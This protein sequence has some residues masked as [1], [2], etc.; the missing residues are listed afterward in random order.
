MFGN[1]PNQRTDEPHL[2]PNKQEVSEIIQTQSNEP[3]SQEHSI[4]LLQIRQDQQIL[5]SKNANPRF[6]RRNSEP[7]R[8]GQTMV[9][10]QWPNDPTAPEMY[11]Q[12]SA[13]TPNMH[14]NQ[15]IHLPQSQPASNQTPG[16]P[17]QPFPHLYNHIRAVPQTLPG[18]QGQRIIMMQRTAVPGFPQ[19]GQPNANLQTQGNQQPQPNQLMRLANGQFMVATPSL[20]PNPGAQYVHKP[21]NVPFLGSQP[22]QV[23]SGQPPFIM[24]GRLPAAQQQGQI[25]NFNNNN[26]QEPSQ[27]AQ[28]LAQAQAQAAGLAQ[29]Q[30]LQAQQLQFQQMQ[31]QRNQYQAQ[32]PV[33]MYNLPA[34]M[35]AIPQSVQP[36]SVHNPP[37]MNPT[38]SSTSAPGLNP[39]ANEFIPN[40]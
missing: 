5:D 25:A 22:Q 33:Q 34:N 26:A 16:Q 15:Q 30:M 10:P 14:Q 7:V 27:Q 2:N 28:A 21:A 12:Q 4:S 9:Q 31:A 8:T 29:V 18:Q 23:F 1:Q 38:S 19:I 20:T 13:P 36:Q 3:D 37:P 32:N 11:T 40:S 24:T 39:N 35:N 17:A 6:P